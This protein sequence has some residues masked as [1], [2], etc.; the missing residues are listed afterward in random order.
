[1]G[2][3]EQLIEQSTAYAD[4]VTRIVEIK[5]DLKG[6]SFDLT[7]ETERFAKLIK[8]LDPL[9]LHSTKRFWRHQ[10]LVVRRFVLEFHFPLLLAISAIGFLAWKSFS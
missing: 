9:L 8:H 4:A 7:S 5:K 6:N 2:Y 1:M 3:S 10:Q